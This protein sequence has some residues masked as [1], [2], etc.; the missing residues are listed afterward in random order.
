VFPASEGGGESVTARVDARFFQGREPQFHRE[1]MRSGDC[2]LRTFENASCTPA[3]TDGLCVETNVCEP[4]PTFVSAG[5]LTITGLAR[6]VEI[7]PMSGLYYPDGPLPPDLF[8]SSADITASLAGADI[9]ALSVSTR[10]VAPIVPDVVD[11][12]VT[13]SNPATQPLMI[14]WT[15]LTAAGETGTRVRLTLNSNNRG[16]GAPFDAIIEC[17][18]ADTA[19][20]IAVAPALLDAFPETFAWRICAGSDCPPSWLRRYR[21]AAA[22]VG[23]REVE[24][25]VSSTFTFGI[26]HP[27]AP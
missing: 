10:G 11:G 24:L 21:R 26:E 27:A 17:D 23:E 13:V 22:P 8:A 4:W 25:R 6:T 18:V 19:G 1:A 15:P 14:R 20:E 5:R 7:D 16:H 12:K 9:P 3:C 2:A